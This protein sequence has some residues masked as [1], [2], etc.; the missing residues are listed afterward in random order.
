MTFPIVEPSD[1]CDSIT[2]A[3]IDDFELND[4]GVHFQLK[5]GRVLI[6]TG[7]F[8]MFVGTVERGTIQ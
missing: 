5:D 4:D 2:G 3:V 6:I 1:F 7:V 8:Q